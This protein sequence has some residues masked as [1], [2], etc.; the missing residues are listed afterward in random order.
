MW[1][2]GQSQGE[3]A[4]TL[5]QL[6][7]AG[8]ALRGGSPPSQNLQSHGEAAAG[9]LPWGGGQAQLQQLLQQP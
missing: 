3:G 6:G 2:R 7:L 1:G 4:A 9:Y 5:P 8:Q